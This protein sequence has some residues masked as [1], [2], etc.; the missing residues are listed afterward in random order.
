LNNNCT[1]NSIFKQRI[2]TE[3][4]LIG[5]IYQHYSGKQ[6]KILHIAYSTDN[7][8]KL[9][10]YQALYN[11]PEFG[12][13]AIWVRRLDEFM[14][15][16]IIKDTPIKTFQNDRYRAVNSRLLASSLDYPKESPLL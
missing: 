11:D 6:Y 1:F 8:E 15:M 13:K 9:V 14:S 16:V 10:V 5:K 12:N 3:T 4:L 7:C 2:A